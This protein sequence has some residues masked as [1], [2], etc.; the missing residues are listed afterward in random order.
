M[1]TFHITAAV[2]ALISGAFQLLMPKGTNQHKLIGRFWMLAMAITAVSSFWLKGFAPIIGT[3]SVIHL[4]SIWVLI[5]VVASIY[6]VKIGN[7]N[8]HKRFA[9]GAYY[10]LVGAG[11]GT[12]APERLVYEWVFSFF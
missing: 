6:Y 8:R 2:L 7:I 3:L 10:G 1:L 9:T 5:C 11:V 4:L 12:L